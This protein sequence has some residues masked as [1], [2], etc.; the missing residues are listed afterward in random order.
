MLRSIQLTGHRDADKCLRV[1]EK[2]LFEPE[3]IGRR[4]KQ[5]FAVRIGLSSLGIGFQLPS[6]ALQ[7]SNR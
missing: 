4:L 5:L 6:T 7:Q 1:L 3:Y 2:A